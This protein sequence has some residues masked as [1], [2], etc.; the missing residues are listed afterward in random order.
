MN[1]FMKN[2]SYFYFFMYYRIKWNKMNTDI[3]VVDGEGLNIATLR[4]NIWSLAG[5]KEDTLSLKN[6]EI[7]QSAAHM[8]M[9]QNFCLTETDGPF[10]KR[11]QA[12]CSH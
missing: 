6:K 7:K 4:C 5:R 9:Q 8:Q 3:Y 2:K 11:S 10:L 1:M 12:V